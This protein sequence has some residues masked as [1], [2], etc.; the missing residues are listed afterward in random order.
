MDQQPP[1]GERFPVGASVR[2]VSLPELTRFAREWQWHHPL[3]PEQ[4]TFA[5]VAAKVSEVGFYHGGD[6]LYQLDG[7]PGIW[8][9]Q[10]LQPV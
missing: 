2:V 5:G 9:Q 1:Y 8:H 3:Q 4:L 7:L 10:C 6:V